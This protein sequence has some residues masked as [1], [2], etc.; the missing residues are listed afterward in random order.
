MFYP[1]VCTDCQSEFALRAGQATGALEDAVNDDFYRADSALTR[2]T[3]GTGIGLALVKKFVVAMGG[4]VKAENNDG[5]GCAVSIVLPKWK[6][7]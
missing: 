5:P 6:E 4:R 3:S 7:A 1:M 2:T